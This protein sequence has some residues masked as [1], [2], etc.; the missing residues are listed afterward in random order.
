MPRICIYCDKEKDESEF[1]LEHVIPQFMGGAYTEDIFK[2][3]DV[4][5]AC[6]SVLGLYVDASFEKTWMVSA[7]LQQSYMGC[8]DPAAP[9]P[10]PL[11]CM[12]TSTL[13]PPY[14]SEDEVCESWLGPL[15]EQVYWI[16]PKDDYQYWYVGGNPISTKS[17]GSRAYFFFSERT[18]KAPNITLISFRSAFKDR[19]KVKKVLCGNID[20]ASASD[21]G[22]QPLDS[23]D[24]ARRDYFMQQQ[25]MQGVGH[26][27]ISFYMEFD[28]RFVSKLA[29]G[30][31]YCLLGSNYLE[32]P[33]AKELRSG[34]WYRGDDSA[35]ACKPK[36]Y[37]GSTFMQ[38]TAPIPKYLLEEYAVTIIIVLNQLGLCLNLNLGTSH[39][40]TILC[41]SPEVVTPELTLKIGG[42]LVVVLY[43]S[44]LCGVQMP[45][46]EYINY[47]LGHSTHS[48]LTPISTRI[49]AQKTYFK[50][51]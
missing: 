5:G 18:P 48:V 45:M 3:R 31:G 26:T 29:L 42:G 4:C 35:E 17:K 43:R 30:V 47:K 28:K 41:A 14:M 27:Q 34:L 49:Q 12:G 50:N 40:W 22:F 11:M 44:L 15:G 16:R 39:S 13:A 37:A 38:T 24:T 51:L 6:N 23:V 20:G 7:W 8:F 36:V 19:K 2:T 25:A 1:S 46:A 9:H 33:Y 21:F 10:I 32:S